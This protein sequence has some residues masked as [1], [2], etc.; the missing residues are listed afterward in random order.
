MV[1]GLDESANI[2]VIEGIRTALVEKFQIHE[3]VEL[4]LSGVTDADVSFLQLIEAA[5]RFCS[6][7]GKR[8]RLIAPP[9]PLL[10]SLLERA[11]FLADDNAGVREFWLEG[12]VR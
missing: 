10:A 7:N 5:R 8:F 4:D 2:R 12:G 1:I 9:G 11:G 3:D 6:A